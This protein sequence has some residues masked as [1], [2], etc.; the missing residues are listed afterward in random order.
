MS[1]S[2]LGASHTLAENKQ[3]NGLAKKPQN[4]H[5]EHF[6]QNSVRQK[7]VFATLTR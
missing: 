3:K 5:L 2:A 4:C 7:P 6:V 1:V